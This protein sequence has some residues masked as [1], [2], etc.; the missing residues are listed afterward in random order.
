MTASVLSGCAGSAR[1]EAPLVAGTGAPV[2]VP[3]GPGEPG[4]TATPGERLGE[5]EARVGAAD[6]RFAEGMIPHHRQALEMA[7]LVPDRSSS[8][9]VRMLAER[10]TAAQRAEIA[11]MTSW[12]ESVGRAPGGHADHTVSQEQMNRLRTARGAAFDGLFL[13]L[14]IA[15]HEAALTMARAELRDGT[16]RAMR[17]TAADVL[18]GQQVEISR[19]REVLGR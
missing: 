19:M 5:P 15:H 1:E 16:D 9:P 4:R 13:T 11:A 14:M 3:G 8:E 17:A 2:V 12:L 18:S 10:I 7:A 6:V